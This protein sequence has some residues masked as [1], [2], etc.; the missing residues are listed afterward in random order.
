MIAKYVCSNGKEYNLIGATFRVMSGNFHKSTW[1]AKATQMET[2]D[3]LY[4]FTKESIAYSLTFTMRGPLDQRKKNLDEIEA[5][6]S[7][8]Q[9]CQMVSLLSSRGAGILLIAHDEDFVSKLADRVY[10]IREGVLE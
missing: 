1:K 10:T 9:A 7:V 5:A 8:Q 4:G 6:L 3:K 2:G